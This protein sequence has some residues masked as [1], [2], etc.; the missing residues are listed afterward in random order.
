MDG[1]KNIITEIEKIP[2]DN[3]VYNNRTRELYFDLLIESIRAV[4]TTG[5]LDEGLPVIPLR[6]QLGTVLT[7][8]NQPQFWRETR[9]LTGVS[10]DFGNTVKYINYKFE[11]GKAPD[12]IYAYIMLMRGRWLKANFVPPKLNNIN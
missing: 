6:N 3:N 4:K 10:K 1:L 9:S 7:A 2:N 11:T 5:K 8:N 12:D